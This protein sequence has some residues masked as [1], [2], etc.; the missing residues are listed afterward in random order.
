VGDSP[1][2]ST[3]SRASFG[4]TDRDA[5]HRNYLAAALEHTARRA[6]RMLDELASSLGHTRRQNAAAAFAIDWRALTAM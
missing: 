6:N 2:V 4:E 5:L 3:S 1:Q